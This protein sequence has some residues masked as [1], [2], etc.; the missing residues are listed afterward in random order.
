[1]HLLA[2]SKNYAIGHEYETVY[3]LSRGHPVVIGDFYG[4]PGVA[5]I[6][7]DEKWCAVGGHGLVLYRLEEPFAQFQMGVPSVQYVAIN[8][9]KAEWSWWVES[10]AQ[11]GPDEI[12]VWLERDQRYRVS[13][14]RGKDFFHAR[15]ELP[16]KRFILLRSVWF[17][18]RLSLFKLRGSDFWKAKLLYKTDWLVQPASDPL[19]AINEAAPKAL[20]HLG[21]GADYSGRLLNARVL[22]TSGSKAFDEAVV[23][24]LKKAR[25]KA[26]D[27]GSIC[28]WS[29]LIFQPDGSVRVAEKSDFTP[30][31]E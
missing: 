9:E 22:S 27:S 3:L 24:S 30:V 4:D 18:V 8:Q 31:I 14:T 6:D 23:G 16:P 17:H 13:F 11:R 28:L 20:I 7:R 15:V 26:H 1:M 19:L 29:R 21:F 2:Q 5:L 25:I 10:L 12:E